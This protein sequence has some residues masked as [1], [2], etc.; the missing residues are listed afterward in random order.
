MK[1]DSNKINMISLK[2]VVLA[3]RLDVH[4]NKDEIGIK[5]ALKYEHFPEILLTIFR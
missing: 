1:F 3:L 2:L 4:V 5:V